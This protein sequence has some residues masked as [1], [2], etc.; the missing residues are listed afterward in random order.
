VKFIYF[1]VGG[2]VIKD[3]SQTTKWQE[4][5]K[6]LGVP[7]AQAEAFRNFFK[8]Y[9]AQACV[10]ADIE[11]FLPLASQEFGIR[12]PRGYSLLADFVGRFEKNDTIVP[13]LAAIPKQVRRG[14]LTNMYPGM[15]DAIF[16]RKLFPDTIW[17]VIIDSSVAK[18]KK[19]QTEIFSLAKQRAG[20][21]PSEILFVENSKMHVVTAKGLGWNTFWYDSSDYGK[22]SFDLLKVLSGIIDIAS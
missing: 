22:A 9:E 4:L 6:N 16:A 10:G 21:S 2:V 15:F 5:Q 7:S 1:D 3:F 13:V 20:V 17:D 8:L 14:L 18:V 12:F 11:K 19:P